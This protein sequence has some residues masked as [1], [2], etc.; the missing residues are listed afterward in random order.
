MGWL[1]IRGRIKAAAAL[2]CLCALGASATFARDAGMIRL[3]GH[4]GPDDRRVTTRD[5][6][7]ILAFQPNGPVKR[8]VETEFAIQIEVD[9]QSANEGIAR[10]GFNL[11]APTTFRMIDSRDLREGIQKVS[12]AVKAK[13]VDWGDRGSFTVLV[14]MSPKVT[15]PEFTPTA[16]VRKAIPVTR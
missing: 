4:E 2:V 9:L 7:R 11:D 6:I 12:F 3:V 8:G 10:V 15:A 5:K 14:N 1:S 16:F 13:P